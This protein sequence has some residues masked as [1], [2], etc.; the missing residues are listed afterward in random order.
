MRLRP[1]RCH[2]EGAPMPRDNDLDGTPQGVF[3]AELRYYRERAGLSQTDLAALV[4]VS[5]DV[6]SKIETGD[7]PPAKDFPERLDAVSALDTREG[8]ARLWGNLR[9]GLRHRAVPGWFQP[10]THFE[11]QAATLRWYEPLLVPGLLQTEDYA[12]A[13]L[14]AEPG[15]EADRLDDQVGARMDRQAALARANAPQLW[16]VVDEGVLHRCIGGAKVMHDQLEHLAGLAE[17]PQTTI[18]V[19]PALAGAHAGLLGGF[20]IADLD[21]S[22]S[23][24]YLETAAEGQ[25]ADSPAIVAHATF[26]FDALRAE[27]LPRA[28]SR[29]LIMKAAEDRWT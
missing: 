21:G 23:M 17:N 6:I 27:A 8:L 26:R 29:D 1:R 14:A 25:I 12:R 5:H 3:G 9:K 28:A 15:V 13:I 10:W 4:N 2:A 11:A 19:I 20:I 18:Q 16:S 22:P 24:V 7:L